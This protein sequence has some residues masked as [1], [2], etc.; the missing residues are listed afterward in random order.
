MAIIYEDVIPSFIENTTIKKALNNGVLSSYRIT[1]NSG[2][3]LHDKGM[4]EPIYDDEGNETGEVVLGFRTSTAGV[5]ANYDWT[6]NPREFYAVL[7]SS[8]PED[9]IFGVTNQPEK[10]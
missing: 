6:E 3:V 10:V 9:Q 2:Y 5:G 4:D 8:V 1:P 7:A